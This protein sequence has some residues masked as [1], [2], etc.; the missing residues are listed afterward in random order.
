MHDEGRDS[1]LLQVRREIGLR[2]RNDPL[3]VRFGATHHSLAPPVL[4]DALGHVGAGA[5]EA[6]ERARRQIPVELCAVGGNLRLQPVEH[7]LRETPG[8]RLRF[9]HERWNRA[10]EHGLGHTTFAVASDIVR[11]FSAAR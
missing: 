6:V 5:I 11:D 9:H 7:V 3:I 10:N 4:D 8:I 2:E 1:D